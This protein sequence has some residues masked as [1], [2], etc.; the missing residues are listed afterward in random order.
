MALIP[1][2]TRSE[3]VVLGRFLFRW[4]GVIGLAAFVVVFCL[5]RPTFASCQLGLPF[6]LVGLVVRFWASGYIGIAGRARE[7]GGQ[8]GGVRREEGGAPRRRIVTGPYRTLR[9]PLYIG[10][11]LLVAGMLVALRPA[12]LA[13]VVVLVLFVVEYSLIVSAEES[14]LALKESRVQ[15]VEG[16]SK[17]LTEA[18]SGRREAGS[19]SF[20][21]VRALC[22]WRT[23]LVTGVAF[24]LAL[25]RAAVAAR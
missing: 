3:W 23:W 13:G 20:I 12:M 24:G 14:D 8:E 19:D 25:L 4:R 10:N 17:D 5:A 6:L 16:A 1:Q 18:D 21:P 7:I 22:E 15:G 2:A 9:H 11:F